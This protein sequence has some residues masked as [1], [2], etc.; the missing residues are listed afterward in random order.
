MQLQCFFVCL[1]ALICAIA[2]FWQDISWVFFAV[3]SAF[4]LGHFPFLFAAFWKIKHAL[5]CLLELKSLTRV[6][7]QCFNDFH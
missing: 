7:P 2:S 3:F 4:S 5:C 6:V 1:Q